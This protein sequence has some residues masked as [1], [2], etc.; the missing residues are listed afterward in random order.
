[1]KPK[2]ILSILA[3]VFIISAFGQKA[4]MEISFTA[5]FKGNHV[6]L[7][8]ILVTNL[9]QG[10]DT[11]LYWN[12][13]VLSLDYTTGLDDNKNKREFRLSQNYP[14]PFS[15]STFFDVF[16]PDNDQIIISIIDIVG[17]EIINYTGTYSF[18]IHKFLL[19]TSNEGLYILKVCNSNS[20]RTLK[21][22]C[23]GE[24][25]RSESKISYIGPGSLI[26]ET[27]SNE[28]ITSFNFAYG[29]SLS[30]IG[31]YKLM[32]IT[33][34]L[35]ATQNTTVIFNFTCPITFI[36]VRDSN[37]YSVVQIGNQCWMAENLAY[38]PSVSPPHLGSETSPYYYVYD[39]YG[40]DVNTAK[41][42]NNYHIYGVLYNWPAAMNGQASS[43]SVPSGVQ[44]ICPSGW[45]LPS[46]EEWKILEGEVDSIY[47]Y[48]DPIWDNPV[49]RGTDVGGNLKE[50][51]TTHWSSPNTG[52]T[53]SSG[54]TALP[55]GYRYHNQGE[56]RG[57]GLGAH[58]ITSAE[59]GIN[60]EWLRHLNYGRVMARRY[61][62][63]KSTGYSVRC[64]MD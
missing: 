47:G 19:N 11:M 26:Y 38:L 45:H 4:V 6:P 33:N 46:D 28:A 56:F 7:D 16:V 32:A 41:D 36:D 40:T 51:D 62:D 20:I 57:L 64:L 50:T 22:Y 17:R 15:N 39:Y 18:G 30:F 13:T 5:T 63:Y 54:F 24:S 21:M 44:G 9:I 14:N 1:M 10:G 60:T 49:W 23:M 53:N 8:S 59:N 52:A 34:T 48:P 3:L 2:I 25:N 43:N 29:D 42:S 12:D 58:F 55:A 37:N 27:K 61:N 31:Y 35:M